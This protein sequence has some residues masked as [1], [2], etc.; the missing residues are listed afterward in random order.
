MENSELHAH[1]QHIRQNIIKEIYNAQSGH[2]GGSLSAADVLT[3]LYFEIMDITKDNASS[4]D[5]DRFVLSKGHASPL[6]YAVLAE[7]GI[8]PED[9]L[10]SFRKI[11]SKLQGHPNMNYVPGVDMS[12]GSLG[13]GF[14]AADGMA[15]ANRLSGNAHRVYALLGDGE[16]EEGEVWETVMAANH[17]GSDNLCAIVDHNGLQIDGTTQDVI[18][19][20]SL[21]DKFSSFGWHVIR[22]NGHDYGQI[23]NAFIEASQ[24]KYHPTVII[25]E[26][27]KGKGVSFM[28]NQVGWHGKAP[29]EEQMKEALKE[30]GAE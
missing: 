17:Y 14:A 16:C 3:V 5:R 26:T 15:I 27:I 2:P 28:E 10:M 4:L 21:G 29:N 20:D 12:T 18:G 23:K 30:L 19:L 22:I 25:A 8:I 11:N 6:L 9:Q 1:A 13:Q 7:K 24:M